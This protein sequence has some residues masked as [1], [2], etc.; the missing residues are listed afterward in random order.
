MKKQDELE[1]AIKDLKN[2]IK[3]LAS[4]NKNNTWIENR[5][6]TLQRN[7]K[8]IEKENNKMTFALIFDCKIIKQSACL[9]YLINYQLK[10]ELKHAR[11]YNIEPLE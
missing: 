9:D 3:L 6:L 7:L 5:L 11:I 1:E 4:E 8:Y 2:I 10:N